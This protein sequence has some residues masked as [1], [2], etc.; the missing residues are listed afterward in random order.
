[1]ATIS[2]LD[3]HIDHGDIFHEDIRVLVRGLLTDLIHQ[4][5]NNPTPNECT[6]FST[7]LRLFVGGHEMCMFGTPS[8]LRNLELSCFGDDEDDLVTCAYCGE[9]VEPDEECDCE[10]EAF[11]S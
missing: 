8:D 5:D 10:F 7:Y 11:P 6:N 4:L 3:I 1:M 9:D 2:N